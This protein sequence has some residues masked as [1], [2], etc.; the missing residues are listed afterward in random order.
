MG[1]PREVSDTGPLRVALRAA[2]GEYVTLPTRIVWSTDLEYSLEI[3]PYSLGFSDGL[4]LKGILDEF[5]ATGWHVE[6]PPDR[7]IKDES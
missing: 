6:F 7:P 2:S 4:L 3:G 1:A 5:I